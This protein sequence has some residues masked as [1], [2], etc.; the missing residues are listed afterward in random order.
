M[1]LSEKNFIHEE[2][3]KHP[4]RFWIWFAIIAGVTYLLWLLFF[5]YS[6]TL[7]QQ[8]E[9]S[10]F[11]QVT[12]RQ[13]SLF[14]L[15]NP[16]FMRSQ[17]KNKT[18]YLPGFQYV[19][20][21][22]IDVPYAD[23]YAIAPP[24]VLFLY[25]TWHRLLSESYPERLISPKE[26]RE[27]LDYSQEWQPKNWREAPQGY[28]KLVAE[29]P[30][31]DIQDLS[32]LPRDVMPQD[33]RLAFI[34]WKNFFKEG[35]QINAVRPS[36][37]EMDAFLKE[38]PHYAFNYWRNIVGKNYLKSYAEPKANKAGQISEDELAPFLRAAFY[39]YLNNGK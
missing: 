13:I 33:V 15:Q 10:P 26:F 25:H 38:Y 6:T 21:I 9:S 30:Q 39:N 4:Y 17:A 19:D 27:F 31:T 22:G 14:V 8:V 24:E 12:N 34:G 16:E 35:D 5:W 3:P 18:G 23:D 36:F 2:Y 32:A 1:P 11:L 7:T 20:R 29:L 28:V 37:D